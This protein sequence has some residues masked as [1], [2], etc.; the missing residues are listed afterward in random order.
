MNDVMDGLDVGGRGLTLS[1]LVGNNGGCDGTARLAQARGGA[2]ARHAAAV[3]VVP[4]TTP[5]GA[6]S[7]AAK[8]SDRHND[9]DAANA[10]SIDAPTAVIDQPFVPSNSGGAGSLGA[11]S[12]RSSGSGSGDAWA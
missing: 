2:M 9:S 1:A 4:D 8:A 6:T 5:H 11:G 7:S 10:R 3:V 12:L